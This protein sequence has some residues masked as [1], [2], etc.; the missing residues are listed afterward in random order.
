MAGK[1]RWKIEAT[2]RAQA[3][4]GKAK[5]LL[6]REQ[7]VGQ[8]TQPE[9]DA[10]RYLITAYPQRGRA[11]YAEEIQAALNWDDPKAAEQAIARFDQLDLVMLQGA[12]M[13]VVYPYSV[14]PTL[15]EVHFPTK[16]EWQP[17]YA[18]SAIDALGVSSLIDQEVAV[19]SKCAYCDAPIHVGL[20]GG[21]LVEAK[22][23]TMRLWVGSQPPANGE[24]VGT[25][26]CHAAVFAC[27]DQHL[28]AWRGRESQREGYLLTLGE[29]AFVAKG[30]YAGLLPPVR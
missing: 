1:S 4:L 19:E 27:S 9:R 23:E 14:N 10:W 21:D 11:A 20:K 24:R 3:A 17:V 2:S 22:P 15:H 29:A 30:L 25:A 26:F 7:T 18:S 12:L 6:H 5:E 8:L 13:A 16:P 28:A